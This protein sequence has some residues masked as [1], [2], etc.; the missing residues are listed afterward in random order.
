ML[1]ASVL[2]SRCGGG[3]GRLCS[4]AFGY[5]AFL[6]RRPI[7]FLSSFVLTNCS[8]RTTA[9][10]HAMECLLDAVPLTPDGTVPV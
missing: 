3:G 5:L 1:N 7:R 6:L 2:F 4:F 9:S 10:Q 8:L